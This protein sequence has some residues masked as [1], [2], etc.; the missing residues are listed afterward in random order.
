MRRKYPIGDDYE[1]AEEIA[2]RAI[3]N[4]G[5]LSSQS[6]DFVMGMADRLGRYGRGTQ[7]SP[8]QRRWF[9]DIKRQL[10]EAES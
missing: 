5:A 9:R 1:W 10:D 6:V 7:L 2:S 8:A 4:A 3:E